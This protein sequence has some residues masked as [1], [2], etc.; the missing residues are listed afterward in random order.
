MVA[1]HNTSDPQLCA[2]LRIT[3]Q[4]ERWP[5][6]TWSVVA[7][8]AHNDRMRQMMRSFSDPFSGGLFAPSLTDGRDRRRAAPAHP[9]T[10]PGTHLGTQPGTYPGTALALRDEHRDTDMRNPFSMLDNMMLNM[11]TRMDDM[12]KNFVSSHCHAS[13]GF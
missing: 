3:G 5:R 4:S 11:R 12:H 8:R 9:G 6:V 7:G 10:H 13:P 1:V 2:T